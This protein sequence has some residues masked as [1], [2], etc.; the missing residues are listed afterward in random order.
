[1]LTQIFSQQLSQPYPTQLLQVPSSKRWQQ[2]RSLGW[3]CSR[4]GGRGLGGGNP[5]GR[6]G[7]GGMG[8]YKYCRPP[9]PEHSWTRPSRPRASAR[10][11]ALGLAIA[12]PAI[13]ARELLSRNCGARSE[14]A[15]RDCREIEFRTRYCCRAR[16]HARGVR[17]VKFVPLSPGERARHVRRPA[18]LLHSTS[19][20]TTNTPYLT[21]LPR[22]KKAEGQAR[23]AATKEANSAKEEAAQA[24]IEDAEWEVGGKK[25]NK[26]QEAD[27][28][29]KTAKADRKADADAQ[30]SRRACC[31]DSAVV[32]VWAMRQ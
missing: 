24:A 9:K 26:K 3:V 32:G 10:G 31:G 29:R 16:R 28:A 20:G 14:P 22:S 25:G 13:T 4:G 7:N 8:G 17:S 6:G 1:M 5:A 12:A 15:R 19:Q 27:A 18:R 23:K 11:R 21:R 2:S 30:A